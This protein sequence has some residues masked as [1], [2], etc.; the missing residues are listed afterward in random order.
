M[1]LSTFEYEAR[2]AKGWLHVCVSDPGRLQQNEERT[3]NT[4]VF[5]ALYTLFC[6]LDNADLLSACIVVP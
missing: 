1:L 3:V 2:M 5:Y 4:I 6:L